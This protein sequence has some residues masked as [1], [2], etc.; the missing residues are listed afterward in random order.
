MGFPGW[1]RKGKAPLTV[2][3]VEFNNQQ[4]LADDRHH[5]RLMLPQAL[6]RSKDARAKTAVKQLEW[7]HV[8]ESTRRLSRLVDSGR[9]SVQVVTISYTGGRW[10]VSFTV[11]HT[12]SAPVAHK[13]ADR[14]GG[15][16]GVDA[17][18]KHLA[19]LSTPVSGLT[20]AAGKVTNPK[21][22]ARALPRLRRLDR[23]LARTEKDSN[24]RQRLLKRR[25]RLHGRV[26]QTRDAAWHV[27]TREVARR[28]D[29]V[30]V[31]HLHVAGMVK[32]RR[33]ARALADAGMAQLRTQL[34]YKTKDAGG[35]LVVADTF[36]PSSKTCSSC[37]SV[38]ATL[39]LAERVYSC[40]TCGLVIDR[41]VNAARNLA[42]LGQ[43][44]LAG[45][46][47][48]SR[49]GDPRPDQPGAHAPARAA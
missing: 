7:V 27:V 47:P 18:I 26:A 17:G 45:L 23:A 15:V 49:N 16:V 24:N 43:R 12:A 14:P 35:L 25:G 10:W 32:N 30:A 37:G 34:G 38:K 1:R 11:K 44:A 41:D 42:H 22:L 29:V 31:E 40:T 21:A 8:V 6:R 4:W 2:T 13:P 39:T 20:D 36:Y 9:A 3:F 5:A 28:F 33:L 46:R 19:V 48:E